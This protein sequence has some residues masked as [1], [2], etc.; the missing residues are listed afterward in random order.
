MFYDVFWFPGFS[1]N[2]FCFGVPWIPGCSHVPLQSSY[3]LRHIIRILLACLA[4]SRYP[5][6]GRAVTNIPVAR[7][8]STPCVAD[9]SV[10]YGE[11]DYVV[12]VTSKIK[13]V[14]LKSDSY[15]YLASLR[16]G[17]TTSGPC[18]ELGCDKAN[19]TQ[20]RALPLNPTLTISTRPNPLNL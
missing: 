18:N 15:H 10:V 9:S 13:S 17:I 1:T 2:H 7:L 16:F 11:E 19:L 8:A 6:I 12:H 14:Q 5:Q 3:L 20:P 4:E